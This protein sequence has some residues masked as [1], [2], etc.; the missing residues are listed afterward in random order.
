MPQ[1]TLPVPSGGHALRRCFMEAAEK[2][3]SQDDLNDKY[4]H[5]TH[6]R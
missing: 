3:G 1:D 6:N 2:R 4:P 5:D